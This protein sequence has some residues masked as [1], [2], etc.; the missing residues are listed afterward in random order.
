MPF[1]RAAIAAVIVAAVCGCGD[2][3]PTTRAADGRVA[4]TLDDFAITPQKVRVPAGRVTFTATNRGRTTHTLRVTNGTR[5]LLKVTTLKPGGRGR[6][7][8]T[9][10]A[11]TFKLYCA[12][13]NHEEL[14]MWGTL[15]VR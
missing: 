7:T 8:A 9:L 3:P 10:P 4:F 1:P 2:A 13:A 12:I 14:G 15:V 11:G 5:D 6:A